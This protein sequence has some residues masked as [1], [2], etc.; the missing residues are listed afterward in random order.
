MNHVLPV[1]PIPEAKE[2]RKIIVEIINQKNT[3]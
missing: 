2:V 3:E 1:Y